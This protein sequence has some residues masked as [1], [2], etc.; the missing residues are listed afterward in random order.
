MQSENQ[1]PLEFVA[2]VFYSVLRASNTF[3]GPSLVGGFKICKF[4]K[5]NC[6]DD[7]AISLDFSWLAALGNSS[8]I[9][10][11]TSNQ[12]THCPKGDSRVF[13]LASARCRETAGPS[14]LWGRLLERYQQL[15]RDLKQFLLARSTGP[16]MDFVASISQIGS[17]TTTWFGNTYDWHT[18]SMEKSGPPACNFF[19][20]NLICQ[21]GNG[22]TFASTWISWGIGGWSIPRHHLLL[23]NSFPG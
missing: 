22:L 17:N 5:N 16:C 9:R 11:S 7:F 6:E 1:A 10:S 2:Q 14:V 3:V 20:E 15:L 19:G 23:A 21:R 4:E 13:P 18:F 12:F 8:E